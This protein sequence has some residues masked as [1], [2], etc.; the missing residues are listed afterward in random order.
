MSSQVSEKAPYAPGLLVS[1]RDSSEA[2]DALAGGADIIDVKEPRLGSL[3]AASFE[4]LDSIVRCAQG[5]V[6][7]TAALG[8]LVDF[9]PQSLPA[10]LFAAKVGLAGCYAETHPWQTKLAECFDAFSAKRVA[11]AYADFQTCRAPPPKEVGS[12]AIEFDCDFL[13]ID[14]HEK[15]CPLR[16][17]L[18]TTDIAEQLH[19]TVALAQQ[20]QVSIVVAGSL[21]VCDFRSILS[22]WRPDFLAV[23]G[24]ACVGNR[25][26]KIS[27]EKVETLKQALSIAAH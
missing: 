10:E 19:A 6:P 7:V 24:A 25:T 14:T 9:S 27:R 3:G 12:A 17:L 11:V 18:R 8:E 23:R 16:E 1:V 26:G 5:R 20:N 21:E 4:A 22:H 13:L 15:T 2:R